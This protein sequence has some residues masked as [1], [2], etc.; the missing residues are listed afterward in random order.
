MR[1]QD[2]E[3]LLAS[4]ERVAGRL[5]WRSSPETA[6]ALLDRYGE[7]H[8]RFHT[9]RHLCEVLAGLEAV[10][11]DPRLQIAAWYHDAVYCPGRQD[12]E[13]RSAMLASVELPHLGASAL[14][15]G[16]VAAAILATASHESDDPALWPLLDAD[17]SI[18]GASGEK[19][20]CYL[21]QIRDEYRRVPDVLYRMGRKRFVRGCLSRDRIFLT[22]DF[23][24]RL[25]A[26]AR[27]NLSNE[28]QNDACG[29]V[30]CN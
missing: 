15:A 3:G 28:L 13:A 9:Q 10:G 7:P 29:V 24:Q 21:C 12:N 4:W 8:R 17:M 14:D 20:G 18:L 27:R 11:A 5:G 6:R 26:N 22:P 19:Y 30:T 16:F 25:E 23:T 2:I 1:T